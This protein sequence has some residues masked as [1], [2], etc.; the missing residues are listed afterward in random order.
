MFKATVDVVSHSLCE[1]HKIY[2]YI[3]TDEYKS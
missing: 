3:H 1:R 2:Y